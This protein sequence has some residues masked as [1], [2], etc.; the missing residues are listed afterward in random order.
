MASDTRYGWVVRGS[1]H[2]EYPADAPRSGTLNEAVE[3]AKT[4]EVN[5]T[6]T[7]EAGFTKGYVHEDGIWRLT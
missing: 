6:L 1:E 3:A 4:Y 2:A 7:D 5:I